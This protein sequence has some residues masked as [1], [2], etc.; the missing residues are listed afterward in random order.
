M[1]NPRPILLAS[2]N[3]IPDSS[4]PLHK[5]FWHRKHHYV[6]LSKVRLIQRHYGAKFFLN[7]PKQSSLSSGTSTATWRWWLPIGV[8]SSQS[9]HPSRESR[10]WSPRSVT[11]D[12]LQRSMASSWWQVSPMIFSMAS[13]QTFHSTSTRRLSRPRSSRWKQEIL[14]S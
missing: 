12:D 3:L 14:V 8:A 5:D 11:A 13:S 4:G 7:I 6:K 10:Y 2:W 9:A 1:V